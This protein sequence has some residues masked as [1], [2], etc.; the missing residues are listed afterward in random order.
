MMNRLFHLKET[1]QK[2]I[3]DTNHLDVEFIILNYNSKD[4]MNEWIF[5]NFEKELKSE[6]VKLYHTE[7]PQYFKMAHSKN[8]VAKWGSGDILVN[9]DVDNYVTEGFTEWCIEHFKK[10]S[11]IVLGSNP[12]HPRACG[13]IAITKENFYKLK[14]YD[15][16]FESWGFD[17]IDFV[18]RAKEIG[19]KHIEIPE[20]FFMGLHHDNKLRF[21]NYK[22]AK[23]LLSLGNELDGNFWKKYKEYSVYD[24]RK[25]PITEVNKN[26]WGECEVKA[27]NWLCEKLILLE[28]KYGGLVQDV[29]VPRQGT[30]PEN[31]P[32]DRKY[33]YCQG[34]DRMKSQHHYYAPIYSKFIEKYIDLDNINVA[35]VGVLTGSGIAIWSDVFKNGTIYGFDLDLDN[36]F[37]N[38]DTLVQ[39]GAFKNNN[40]LVYEF[41]QYKDNIDYLK[42]IN[43]NKF[44]IVIDDATHLIKPTLNTFDSFLPNLKDSFIY[45]IED[46]P[47]QFESTVKDLHNQIKD[48]DSNLNI[49]YENQ[50]SV[51]T[52]CFDY[53]FGE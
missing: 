40:V 19:L 39:K 2:N 8:V 25:L 36:Y 35:E 21:E 26:G 41:D 16:G 9:L 24:D 30:V 31:F 43:E 32:P 42:T 46:I 47:N 14:G 12:P 53:K 20:E 5:Q 1:L 48:R 50:F 4:K 11:N 29:K 51:I 15:E 23:K 7:E 52:K 38:K 28:Q 17:D 3:L 33:F 45:I 6:R 13:K 22:D 10:N 27:N 37:N 18:R 44:D 49:Y 34:G